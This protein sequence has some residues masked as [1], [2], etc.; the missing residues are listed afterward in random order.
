MIDILIPVMR[1]S[2]IQPLIEN[3]EETTEVPHRVLWMGS[4]FETG[5]ESTWGHRINTMY[6]MSQEPY[7]FL[8]ADDILFH[9][10]WDEHVLKAMEV[11]DGVV[12]VNDMRNPSGTLALVSRRYIN[13]QSGCVDT[14]GVVIYPGYRHNFS[15][16]ELFE[17][18][19]RRGKFAY[20]AP[21]IVEHVH[22]DAGKAEDDE[23][24]QL[25]RARFE[26]DRALYESRCHLWT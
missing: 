17:T 10:G 16:T 12:A 22:P 19:K 9:E 11:I 3:I 4:N 1:A 7:V 15:E 23:V 13:E 25:G 21:S 6:L 14:K 2:K 5:V 24:Y 18:A 26:E 8:G 20:C